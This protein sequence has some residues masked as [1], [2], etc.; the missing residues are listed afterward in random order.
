M[1]AQAVLLTYQGV[2]A[3]TEVALQCWG[4]LVKFVKSHLREW[5]VKHW[6]TTLETNKDGTHHLHL[7]LDFFTSAER[8]ARAFSFEGRCP[9]VS[10]NDL[11]GEGWSRSKQ[12]RASVDR[13][14]F[15]VWANKKGTTRDAG[16]KLC[17][18][19][20]YEPAWTDAK[21]TYVVKAE[22]PEK[23]W[24]AYKL[25]D[26]VYYQDYLFQCKDKVVAK[27]RNFEAYLARMRAQELEREI[28][29]RTSRIRSTPA[30]YQ[31][32]QRVAQADE[33]L[34]LFDSEA[35]R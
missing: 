25:D 13:G 16:G 34:A 3:S 9:N 17:V 15:Y 1:R 18:A 10:A 21:E 30:I 27:K 12:W 8:T 6:T 11:L 32:F 5:G 35:M 22:W 29:V 23:L 31:P 14:H 7:M 4:R 26:S 19:A 20:N 24:K 2:D 28:E 33:F